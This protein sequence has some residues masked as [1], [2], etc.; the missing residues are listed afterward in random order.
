M[1]YCASTDPADCVQ[2]L[3]PENKGVSS[4]ILL[5]TAYR[6]K[7][8]SSM[9][10]WLHWIFHFLPAMWPSCFNSL[11]FISLL[12]HPLPLPPCQNTACLFLSCPPLSCYI[13][14]PLMLA[15]SNKH[16]LN[17]GVCI[18]IASF[19]AWPFFFFNGLHNSSGKP[20][21]ELLSIGLGLLP[22]LEFWIHLRQKIII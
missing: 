3:S 11:S 18:S 15:G 13:I 16:H 9:C 1:F 19:H 4:Y 17:L 7:K 8:Q 22:L 14:P 10:M 20:D 2:R 12:C 5:Q 6:S 21:R